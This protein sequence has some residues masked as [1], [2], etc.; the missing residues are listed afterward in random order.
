MPTPAPVAVVSSS[1]E[2]SENVAD[3]VSH[4]LAEEAQSP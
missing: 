4:N 3:E 2:P 1:T